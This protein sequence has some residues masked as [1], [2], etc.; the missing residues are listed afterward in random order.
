MIVRW[1]PSVAMIGFMNTLYQWLV[2]FMVYFGP[3]QSRF[4]YFFGTKK[5]KFPE[6]KSQMDFGS[7][8]KRSKKKKGLDSIMNDDI[9]LL[10]IG[11]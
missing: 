8:R 5:I 4:R 3:W 6:K 7:S 11:I 2:M 9:G 10:K 1:E